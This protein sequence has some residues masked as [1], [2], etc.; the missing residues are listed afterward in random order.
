[1]RNCRSPTLFPLTRAH[2]RPQV[3]VRLVRHTDA[4]PG[5]PGRPP[6]PPAPAKEVEV[7]LTRERVALSPLFYAALP[8]PE[9]DRVGYLKLATFSQNA[10]EAVADAIAELQVGL[11]C[12]V[13]VARGACSRNAAGMA[14]TLII[15]LRIL[16]PSFPNRVRVSGPTSSTCAPTRAA[17]CR[18]QPT[19]RASS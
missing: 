17:W 10:G 9:G 18:R 7:S 12:S 19:W 11:G 15:F 16:S 1:M 3:R 13:S 8:G 5:V 14:L 4:I 2:N 6:P